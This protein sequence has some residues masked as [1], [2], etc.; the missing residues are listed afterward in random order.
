M[1]TLSIVNE[2]L[3]EETFETQGLWVKNQGRLTT[4]DALNI[5]WFYCIAD[6]ENHPLQGINHNVIHKATT[7]CAGVDRIGEIRKVFNDRICDG[8]VDCFDQSDEND[9]LGTCLIDD[10]RHPAK[11]QCPF[12][13]IGTHK[14]V[15][16]CVGQEQD[17]DGNLQ[18]PYQSKDEFPAWRCTNPKVGESDYWIY[19][20]TLTD[21]KAWPIA[22][23]KLT[24]L[25][26]TGWVYSTRGIDLD[27]GLDKYHL[28]AFHPAPTSCILFTTTIKNGKVVITLKFKTQG[29]VE[30]GMVHIK[31]EPWTYCFPTGELESFK[32]QGNNIRWVGD[33]SI[34]NPDQSYLSLMQCDDCL[35][36]CTGTKDDDCTDDCLEQQVI[37]LGLDD[38][39]DAEGDTK[40]LFEKECHFN[41]VTSRSVKSTFSLYSRPYFLI[42]QITIMFFSQ[43]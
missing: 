16:S 14:R 42:R 2:K 6:K 15:E 32:L 12:E 41:V 40:C 34:T 23:K 7:E 18:A 11:G 24:G 3:M 30:I 5:D 33:I 27:D 28:R 22:Q 29:D 20:T 17:K 4:T 26:T 1:D 21:E 19:H 8:Y 39:D 9:D 37:N 13:I 10:T 25:R 31:E 38:D 43:R 35:C 36:Q